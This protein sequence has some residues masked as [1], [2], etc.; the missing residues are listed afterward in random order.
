MSRQTA[1]VLWRTLVVQ[2]IKRQYVVSFIEFLAVLLLVTLSLS[3]NN[4][5]NRPQHLRLGTGPDGSR[6]RRSG[7]SGDDY[8]YNSV[9]YSP[10]NDYNGL[11]MATAYPKNDR[12]AFTDESSL[13]STCSTVYF[14]AC[15]HFGYHVDAGLTYTLHYFESDNPGKNGT[16]IGFR[17]PTQFYD[18]HEAD[19]EMWGRAYLTQAA[20]NT[21]H[22]K[23]HNA[24]G[25]DEIKISARP[26]PLP[27]F[28]ENTGPYRIGSLFLLGV[29]LLFPALRLFWRL[30]D[31]NTGGLREFQRLMGLSD[32]FYWTGH[33]AC[34]FL[35]CL[36]HSG[37]C[38]Y[39]TVVQARSNTG[40][41]FLENTDPSLL[42]FVF[43][44]HNALQLLLVMLVA[45]LFTSILPGFICV[46]VLC[47]VLPAWV[48]STT[49]SLG[50]LAQFMFRDRHLTLLTSVLPTVATYNLLTVLGIQN[51]F[52]GGASWGKTFRYVFGVCPVNVLD[53]WFVN[54]VVA[55][56]L[57]L[58]VAFASNVFPWNTAIPQHPLFLFKSSFWRPSPTPRQL[59]TGPLRFSDERFERA[60]PDAKPAVHI[61]DLTV[62]HGA[63]QALKSVSF[64]AFEK[65][66]TALVGRNGA[67]K[68]T[69][70]NVVAGLQKPTSGRVFVCGYDVVKHTN[71]A[72]A[73]IGFCPQRDLLFS[74]L[75]V[76]E[77][78]MYFGTLKHMQPGSLMSAAQDMVVA[79]SLENDVRTL[80]QD[81]KRGPTKR[82]SIAIATLGKP[83]VVLVDEPT[84]GLDRRNTHLV[85]HMLLQARRSSALLIST[86]DMTEA[87][88][89]ADRVVS[90]SQG[91][92][93]CN[94]SPTH[95]KSIY[96][97]SE[98][99]FLSPF[100]FL[101]VLQN[102]SIRSEVRFSLL[103]QYSDKTVG[104]TH[105]AT[106]GIMKSASA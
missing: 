67:G 8:E 84:S 63:K 13:V 22:I 44:V 26:I 27:D 80:V 91:I 3:L 66:A 49:G 93:V 20:I 73:T 39:C 56:I 61:E 60:P 86:H 102:S 87:D 99:G 89:L 31:E 14:A 81:L 96:G 24:T 83:K 4:A 33:F 58:L 5:G 34:S 94:A 52:E 77:H 69:L 9:F 79:A 40:N 45:C 103:L 95:L 85:W 68:T 37:L 76:W 7:D 59:P 55:V 12:K 15:V 92:V 46:A 28:P 54:I 21:A 11:L 71:V 16:D 82:L 98:E 65:Q 29:G 19:S 106:I 75:T 47:F 30:C 2:C 35:T 42:F 88:V 100:F 25:A 32:C 97:K 1:A 104:A 62:S 72:R 64:Q 50:S 18:G 43:A 17:Y 41:A 53:I 36:V 105:E 48:L 23:L 101:F 51:D 10:D 78:L 74:D 6:Q 90:L 38:V 57:I 70:M